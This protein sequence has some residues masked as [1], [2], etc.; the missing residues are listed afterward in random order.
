MKEVLLAASVG[1]LPDLSRTL[2]SDTD[3]DAKASE[4][5]RIAAAAGFIAR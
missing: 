4:T 3:R 5:I 2:L 1:K